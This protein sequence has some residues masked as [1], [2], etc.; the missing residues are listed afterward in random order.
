MVKETTGFFLE[1]PLIC[2]LM[3]MMAHSSVG[4]I[5]RYIDIYPK[6]ECQNVLVLLVVALITRSFCV[7]HS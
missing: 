7:F 5:Y 6:D 1:Y 3:K 2:G 4:Y